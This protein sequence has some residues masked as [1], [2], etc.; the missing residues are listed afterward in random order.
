M[1]T[2]FQPHICSNSSAEK[3]ETLPERDSEANLNFHN[4][5]NILN[6][7]HTGMR[8][9][10]YIPQVTI[11]GGRRFYLDFIVWFQCF[12]SRLIWPSEFLWCWVDSNW[13]WAFLV[14]FSGFTAGRL[15]QGE[16]ELTGVRKL[17]LEIMRGFRS[18]LLFRFCGNFFIWNI[19]IEFQ[20]ADNSNICLMMDK[21]RYKK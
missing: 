14:I 15:S 3:S 6:Y 1:P 19:Q 20:F 2:P 9:C 17:I 18:E 13:K 8:S 7:V 10:V 12:I 21:D 16:R 11:R 5:W 4:P